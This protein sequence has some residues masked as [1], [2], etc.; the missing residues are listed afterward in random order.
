[1]YPVHTF[2]RVSPN[3]SPPTFMYYLFF[4]QKIKVL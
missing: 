1:M 3:M 2:P 4:K